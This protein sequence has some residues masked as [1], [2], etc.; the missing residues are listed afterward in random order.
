M[1]PWWFRHC[2]ETS[3]LKPRHAGVDPRLV[4]RPTVELCHRN[5]RW[6]RSP[7]S[8]KAGLRFISGKLDQYFATTGPPPLNLYDTPA[9]TTSMVWRPPRSARAVAAGSVDEELNVPSMVP[10]S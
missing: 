6:V 1:R 7:K 8:P 4:Y 10:K 5:G 3:A 9:R 2:G